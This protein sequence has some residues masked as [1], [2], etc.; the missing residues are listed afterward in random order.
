MLPWLDG[1]ARR[2]A[3]LLPW[4]LAALMPGGCTGGVLDPQGPIGA[5]ERLI[6]LDALGIML[7]IV[8]PVIIAILAFSWWY[9]ASN[10]KA[11]YLPDWA[12]SGRIEFVVWAIPTLVVVF[13]GGIA[14]ISSHELDPARPLSANPDPLEVQV[15]SLDWKW[16]FI[17]P[18]QGVAS[19]NRLVVPAGVPIRFSLTSASVMNAFFVPQ[20][21]TMIYTMNGM[22]THLYLQ[23][24]APGVFHGLSSQVQ[25]R[26]IFGHGIRDAC[27][28]VRR[29]RWLDRRGAK[30]RPRA[31]C[32]ELRPTDA[33]EPGCTAVYLQI[34]AAPAVR[35][36]CRAASGARSRTRYRQTRIGGVAADE[37]LKCLE[38]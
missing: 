6:L 29:L 19:V 31:G 21:G 23:A 5:G 9:R 27:R 8:V 36:Y 14:W 22:A 4:A 37:A 38:S 28:T 2:G 20:L 35:G 1:R 30:F 16:L 18:E 3:S 7:M 26:R 17:Y 25:R 32:R 33:A 15:V 12:Y 10:T 24:D 13:L 34:R 11:R